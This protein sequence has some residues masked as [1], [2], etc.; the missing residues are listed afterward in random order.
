V[1]TPTLVGANTYVKNS[2][3]DTFL[4]DRLWQARPKHDV[5]D[6][7]WLAFWFSSDTTRAKMTGFATGTSGSMKNISK[8][9]VLRLKIQVPILNAQKMIVS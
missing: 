4:P 3:G 2:D 9:L 1:N 6:M 5:V 8:P 7:Q